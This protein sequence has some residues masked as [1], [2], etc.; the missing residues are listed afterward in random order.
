MR[1][2]DAVKIPHPRKRIPHAPR[3]KM[4]LQV[5]RRY[6]AEQLSGS[7]S[8]SCS[9]C[10]QN[11][12]SVGKRGRLHLKPMSS[13]HKHAAHI[14]P[15]SPSKEPTTNT[16]VEF[17]SVAHMHIYTHMHV[18]DNIIIKKKQQQYIYIYIVFFCYYQL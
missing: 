5:S 2:R 3:H 10:V 11:G 16:E 12:Q 14:S 13:Q 15:G 8:G 18:Y 17:N 9:G 4:P 7:M 6:H 1:K